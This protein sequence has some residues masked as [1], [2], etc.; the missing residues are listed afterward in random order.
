MMFFIS[1]FSFRILL[2]IFY[3][4]KT[5]GSENIPK[6]GPF[7]AASNHVSYMD[8][9]AIGA[10][11]AR[12]LYFIA[13]DHLYKNIFSRFWH[14]SVGCLKMKR[15]E[16]DYGAVKKMLTYLKDKKPLALFPE[17]T[18]SEDGAIKEP[19]L[20]VGFLAIKSGVPVIPC[21]ISGTDKALPRGAKFF[22]KGRVSVYIG[23]PIESANFKFEGE[24]KE[25][26]RL[27]SKKVMHSILQLKKTYEN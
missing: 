3:R 10:A 17:G 4:F 19:L 16:S 8:P 27:F 9:P 24:K 15:G 20:G 22:K 6:K 23:K 18:R 12:R 13:G 21:F 2:T 11:F 26:Y 14:T 5:R 7:I 1:K 25:A